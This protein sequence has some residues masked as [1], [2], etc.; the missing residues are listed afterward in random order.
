MWFEADRHYNYE[1]RREQQ[2]FSR[3][4]CLIQALRA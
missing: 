1:A 4:G 2:G 3:V